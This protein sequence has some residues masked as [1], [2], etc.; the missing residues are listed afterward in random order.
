VKKT[1]QLQIRVSREEKA[2]IR[3]AAKA[4]N[5]DI[6]TWVLR[7]LLPPK[8]TRLLALASALSGKGDH[9]YVLA[10][11]HDL[12]TGLSATAFSAVVAEP[13]VLRCDVYLQNY[14]AAML[15][16]AAHVKGVRPPAWLAEVPRL[17]EPRFGTDLQ[18]LRLHL[19]AHSPVA[20]RRRNIFIDSTLGDRV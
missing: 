12:L 7:R 9:R 13:V 14:L 11:L 16:H 15:E 19:L 4:A 18:S 17:S 20:F 3:K 6:S 2:E 1:Q 10:E 8:R 5:L